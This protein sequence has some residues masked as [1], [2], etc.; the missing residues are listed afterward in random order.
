MVT[1]PS[2]LKSEGWSHP[3]YLLRQEAVPNLKQQGAKIN[4]F[5]TTGGTFPDSASLCFTRETCK[6]GVA[7]L[8]QKVKLFSAKTHT[9]GYD[10]SLSICKPYPK[11]GK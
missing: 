10:F 7:Y 1:V 6:N 4:S 2:L 11:K 9:E 3:C 5:P 8:T